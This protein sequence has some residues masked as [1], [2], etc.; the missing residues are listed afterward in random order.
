[1]VGHNEDQRSEAAAWHALAGDEACRRLRT[2]P[3]RGLDEDEIARRL[4]RHGP[5][6]LPGKEPPGLLRI[7][8]QQF[9]NPLIYVL[10]AA[11]AVS[12]VTDHLQDAVFILLVVLLNAVIGTCSSS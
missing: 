7:F 6:L 10:L 11:G 9:A 5:N 2:D 1:M 3:D 12:L 8:L 4:E